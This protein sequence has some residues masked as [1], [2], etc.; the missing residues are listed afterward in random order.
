M[1]GAT[2]WRHRIHFLQADLLSALKPEGRFALL[3][4]NLPYVPRAE[5]EGLPQGYQ[6]L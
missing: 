3:V 5:W 6:G 1:P 4:A 2:G